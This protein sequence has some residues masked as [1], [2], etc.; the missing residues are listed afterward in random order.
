MKKVVLFFVF[1]INALLLNAQGEASNWYF[2]NG[3]GLVFDVNLGTVAADASAINTIS[4]TEGCSSISD[5]NG[6]LL[7]YTD[8]KS[9]WNANH[10]LMPNADYNG[11][12][13]LLGDPSSTSSAVIVPKPGNTN[14]YYIFTVDEPHHN[15]SWA[16]PNQG[17]ADVNGNPIAQYSDNNGN[18]G[19]VPNVDDGFNNGFNYSL[20]DLTLNGGTGDVV[21]TEKNIHLVT[22]NPND[23]EQDSY[24]CSEK[25]TA[26]EH[27][28]GVSY[29]VITQFIDTFYAFRVDSNGVDPNPV[30]SQLTPTI[31]TSGYRRNAIGYIKTSPNGSKLA[32]CHNQNGSTEGGAENNS[33]SFWL[34]DFDNS[35]GT[36]SNPQALLQNTTAYGADFSA[37]SKKLYVS[38]SSRVIQFDLEAPDIAASQVTVHQQTSFIGAVQLGPDGRIY[39]CNTQDNFSLD[40]INNPNE[41]AFACGY[42]TN[43][44]FL[45]PGT[46]ATLGLPPFIQSFLIARIETENVCFGDTTIFSVDSSETYTSILWDFGD[47]NTSTDDSPMHMYSAP[48]TYSVTATLT[49]DSETKTFNTTVTIYEVPIANQPSDIDI[50]DDNNDGVSSFDFSTLKDAEVL[51]SQDANTFNVNYFETLEDATNNINAINSL[52]NNTSNPQEIFARINNS[53]HNECFDLTSFWIT[54]Y[55]TPTANSIGDIVV[56]DNNDDGDIANGQVTSNLLE[57]NDTVLGGQNPLDYAISYHNSQGDADN[58]SN[59]LGNTYYNL[60]PNQEEIFVRIENVLHP[61]CYDTTSYNLIVNPIPEAYNVSLFQCDEDGIPEGFTLFN[62]TEA[63][64]D[65]TGGIPDRTVQYFTS[66]LDAQNTTN[67]IDGNA[68]SNI[69]NPQTLYVQVINNSTGCFNISELLLEVSSTSANDAELTV[70]DDDGLEDG[71]HTFNLSDADAIVLNNLPPDVTLLYYETYENALLEI[72]PLNLNFTNTIPYTQTI[73]ARVEDNNACYGINEVNLE[74]FR[75]PDLEITEDLLY[76]LNYYPELITLTGGVLNDVPNNYYFN[77]STG[78]TT[79]EIQV[80]EVGTYS[81][82]VT[83][84]NGCSKER[85]I[86]VTPSNIATIDSFDIIDASTNN[87]ITVNVSGEGD[88]EYSIDNI[89]GPYQDSN[90][91]SNVTPGIHTVYVRDKNDCGIVEDLVSVIGFPKF[92]TPNQDTYNDTWQVQGVNTPNQLQSTIYIFDRYGKLITQ[93]DPRGPGWDGTYNGKLMPTSDYWFYVVLQDGREF[94]SH[95]TLKR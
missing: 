34:Y 60:I 84:T 29:W 15:N 80:N 53:N 81:V 19:F 55:N 12:L 57:L 5:P 85:T 88:Y 89:D 24:K 62:L 71:F 92:F 23:Q 18:G 51:G 63:N 87:S 48:G 75:L 1:T 61:E 67:A 58:N 94:K 16:F 3:A 47:T 7:F 10:Q 90:T 13:G 65:L 22:Y 72:N 4:T 2:G 20:V 86:T 69:E 79:T 59:Q 44:I 41:V 52:Y 77:W 56:C 14:Q 8:G 6:N 39:I 73:Y 82:I 42:Q 21:T 40:V 50:C 68:Y 27:A 64:E 36:V 93:L 38:N 83:N 17:P 91:F 54:I 76:C 31:T 33:G 37:N 25:I 74:V 70:C 78:E 45:S 11:G 30:T 26:V 95:F 49:T 28:D 9:V 35:S 46:S 66:L 32:V 43:G